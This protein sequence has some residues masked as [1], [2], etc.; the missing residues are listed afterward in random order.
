MGINLRHYPKLWVTKV[1]ADK[2]S[3]KA[4]AT[5]LCVFATKTSL[6]T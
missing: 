6:E 1:T 4:S 5:S 2:N 3:T